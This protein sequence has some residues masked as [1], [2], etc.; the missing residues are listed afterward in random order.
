M[1]LPTHPG[2]PDRTCDLTG[3]D[4][5]FDQGGVLLNRDAAVGCPAC[6]GTLVIGEIE[7]C[8][9]AG[10]PH[11]HG[12]LFRQDVFATLLPQMRATSACTTLMPKP[13]DLDEL[14]VRRI[15][16]TCDSPLETHP[17]CGP[18]NAVIDSCFPC[19]LIWCD[20][21]EFTKLVRAPGK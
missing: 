18:G 15:C 17:Y 8:Q 6:P 2:T 14:K 20:Q 13:I 3:R 10:C 12:M 21:G 9:F 7:G 4:A 11:C 1:T 16:P 19:K 5:T